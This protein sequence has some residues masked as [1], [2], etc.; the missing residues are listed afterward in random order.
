LTPTSFG[1]ISASSVIPCQGDAM[2][3]NTIPATASWLSFGPDLEPMEFESRRGARA[4]GPRRDS[5]LVAG[6]S[7]EV[8]AK[9]VEAQ[10]ATAG[11]C[12]LDQVLDD[13]GHRKAYV[14]AA[15]V[16]WVSDRDDA[17]QE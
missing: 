1:A 6:T 12:E 14:N 11:W 13:G 3:E 5:L 10:R 16:R 2:Q 9:L 15:A 8:V 4:L 17:A 7:E